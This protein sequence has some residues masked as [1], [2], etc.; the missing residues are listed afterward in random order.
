M[1]LFM[2]G[3]VDGVV[4]RLLHGKD[5]LS[6]FTNRWSSRKGNSSFLTVE[7]MRREMLDPHHRIMEVMNEYL[8]KVSRTFIHGY[9][10]SQY[11]L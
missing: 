6:D 1:I 9:Q 2:E 5:C 7:W 11:S 4:D 3:V 8:F 10:P